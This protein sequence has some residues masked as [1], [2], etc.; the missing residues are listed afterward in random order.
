MRIGV[1]AI[2][3]DYGKHRQMLESLGQEAPLVRTE[4]ELEEC[5]GLIVP[6]GESTT[7][8][9][10]LQKHGLWDPLQAF[11]RRKAIFGTCAGLILLS[12]EVRDHKLASLNLIDLEVERNAYGRQIDSFIDRV[13]L[14]LRGTPGS[15]EGVFIRAPR[16]IA[17]GMEVTP[18]G[19]HR[20][21]VVAAENEHIMVSTFHPELTES[22]LLHRHFLTKVSR[23]LHD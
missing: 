2:Q 6:G 19:W 18:L 16:I 13:R 17:C 15:M 4:R 21:E 7:L 8:T 3:G 14:D 5:D 11:G 1:L 9:I 23:F 12:R 10:L 20:E 22:T